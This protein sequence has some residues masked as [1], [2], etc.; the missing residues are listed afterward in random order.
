M[1]RQLSEAPTYAPAGD[2][3]HLRL[4]VRESSGAYHA[5]Q[6]RRMPPEA[7]APDTRPPLAERTLRFMRSV[8]KAKGE[9]HLHFI[10]SLRLMRDCG[11]YHCV[12]YDTFREFLLGEFRLA[13]STALEYI[14]VG[15]ALD[16]LL[17]LKLAYLEA[18]VSWEQI[19]AITRVATPETEE[20]WL[21]VAIGSSVEHIL[22][23]VREAQR[24][25]KNAPRDRKHGLPNVMT[26]IVINLTV[27]EKERVEAAF[28]VV[29]E[30]PAVDLSGGLKRGYRHNA[31]DPRGTLV[32][33]T[34]GILSGAIPAWP[35]APDSNGKGDAAVLRHT[36]AQT[37]LY[38]TCPSCRESFLQTD[39]GPVAI[40]PERVDA[41]A[42]E[43][44]KVVITPEEE[45]PGE[46]LPPGETDPP[47]SAR[48][49]GQVLHRDGLRCNNPGCGRREGLHAHHVHF[50][51]D[52]GRTELDNL[53]TVCRNCHALIHKGFLQVT[54]TARTGF[55]WQPHPTF[56]D[57]TSTDVDTIL[58]ELRALKAELPAPAMVP[59]D[60]AL[61][62]QH[63]PRPE[64]PPHPDHR[65][66]EDQVAVLV[67][68]GCSREDAEERVRWAFYMLLEQRR[69]EAGEDGTFELPDESTVLYYAIR[70]PQ[71]GADPS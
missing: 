9:L 36:P 4:V 57:N 26:R 27:E 65:R 38:R 12:G 32:R 11:L 68:M 43:A 29:S 18:K 50:R 5:P 46:P 20:A 33:W 66:F 64:L 14:R 61:G 45:E 47:N 6:E 54:G 3:P 51:A 59:Q 58:E 1:F 70:G 52:G 8:Y 37:V 30:G 44:E 21:T 28:A 69:A 15:Q 7:V 49:S 17:L 34:D 67:K 60:M 53:V 39:D 31:D 35:V 63:E 48:L 22:A 41:V 2:R 71:E 62:S 10:D 40:T 19:R 16:H 13:R 23:E 42:D 25:G 55:R 56:K 24:R